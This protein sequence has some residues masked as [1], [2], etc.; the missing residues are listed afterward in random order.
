MPE[1]IRLKDA[2]KELRKYADQGEVI[3]SVCI[4][5]NNDA[6]LV[7]IKGS[8]VP[9]IKFSE[10]E[11]VSACTKHN[12]YPAGT[13]HTHP[14]EGGVECLIPS[15]A[16]MLTFAAMHNDFPLFC[17]A[18]KNNFLCYIH[19]KNDVFFDIV[20]GLEELPE[21]IKFRRVKDE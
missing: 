8:E 6:Y 9:T 4:D 14:C 10:L 15:G 19:V 5:D 1:I 11:V 13:L 20:G 17:I 3:F 21:K 7:E 2:P 18:N 16:D 12:L